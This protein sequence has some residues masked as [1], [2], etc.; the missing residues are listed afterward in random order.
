M[1][2]PIGYN[3]I[4]DSIDFEDI[5]RENNIIDKRK[6]EKK[7]ENK[8][9]IIDNN[10]DFKIEN[11]INFFTNSNKSF[12]KKNNEIFNNKN[13][14]I[15]SNVNLKYTNFVID[16][17]NSLTFNSNEDKIEYNDNDEE[18]E[19]RDEFFFTIKEPLEADIIMIEDYTANF[20]DINNFADYD[21]PT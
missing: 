9:N 18:R 19:K 12:E 20:F 10:N 5:N 15:Q 13:F 16:N 14:V 21:I 11:N 6:D 8:I 7:S 17:F 3:H 1:E 4:S 2:K